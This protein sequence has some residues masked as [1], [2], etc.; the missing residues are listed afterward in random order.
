MQ[1]IIPL[2]KVKF[3]LELQNI[4][5]TYTDAQLEQLIEYLVNKIILITGR[6]INPVNR[7]DQ[8]FNFNFHSKFYNLKHYPV[9]T[10]NSIKVDDTFIPVTDYI[11]NYADGVIQFIKPLEKGNQILVDYVSQESETFISNKI[12]PVLVDM[13]SYNV[14]K[15]PTKNATSI[16]EGD[17]SINFDANNTELAI[18]T[19]KLKGLRRNVKTR[20]L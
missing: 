12:L 10:V 2:E 5:T 16:T 11:I 6:D 7:L 13:I 9:K 4:T 17:V 19:S 20:M 15:D 1:E 18:L 14:N 8:E 3:L